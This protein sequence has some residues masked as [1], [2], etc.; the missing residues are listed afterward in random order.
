VSTQHVFQGGHSVVRV[1]AYGEPAA[2]VWPHMIVR[3]GGQTIGD[4]SVDA[5]AY[6]AYEL[7][8]DASPGSQPVSV[9]FDN[10]YYQSGE[11]RNLLLDTV[12]IEECL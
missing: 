11:D 1:R 5:T 6:R 9:S 4:V 3:A 12:E 10:D 8:Y 7:Y 2:S